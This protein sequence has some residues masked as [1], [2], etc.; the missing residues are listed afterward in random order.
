MVGID[1]CAHND[2]RLFGVAALARGP[3][4]PQWLPG[5]DADHPLPPWV[6]RPLLA[7]W[8]R[9]LAAAWIFAEFVKW[10]RLGNWIGRWGKKT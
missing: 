10:R 8:T 5:R 9:V 2:Y 7:G 4:W 6:T 1:D 3:D